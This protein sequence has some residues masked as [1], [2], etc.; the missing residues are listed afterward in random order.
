MNPIIA[1]MVRDW[2]T[3]SFTAALLLMAICACRQV[4]RGAGSG[5]DNQPSPAA[6][7][8]RGCDLSGYNA[9]REV[10]F[11]QRAIVLIAKPVYPPEALRNGHG[12]SVNVDIVVNRDG[13]VIAACALNGPVLLQP[14]AQKA[15]LSCKFKKHFGRGAPTKHAYQRDVITYLFIA[16]QSERAEE[17][18]Y[19]VVRP[20]N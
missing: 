3:R 4:E 20:S 8:P 6:E 16:N 2:D 19:I 11:A 12:G 15:A 7:Q 18:R 1:T 5:G 13:S 14:A 10:H 9:H 17:G